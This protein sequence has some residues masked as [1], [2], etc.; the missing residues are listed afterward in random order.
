M[1]DRPKGGADDGEARLGRDKSTLYFTSSRAAPIDPHR[2]R[3]QAAKDFA[4]LNDW[5]NSNNN[6]WSLSLAP[7]LDAAKASAS[8]PSYVTETVRKGAED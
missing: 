8:D 1:G 2:T 3:A 5:D 6:V 4:R 7:W